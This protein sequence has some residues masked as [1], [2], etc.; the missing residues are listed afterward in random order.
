MAHSVSAKDLGTGKEQK[1]E[2]AAVTKQFGAAYQV[3][4]QLT[5]GGYLMGHTA[6]GYLIAPSGEVRTLF[7][8]GTNWQEMLDGVKSL[9]QE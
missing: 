4:E 1:I 9:L 8:S 7:P 2:I 6:F 3:D 5:D